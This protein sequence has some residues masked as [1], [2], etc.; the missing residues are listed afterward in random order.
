[1][2]LTY[3]ISLLGSCTFIN[4]SSKFCYLVSHAIMYLEQHIR[5][6]AEAALSSMY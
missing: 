1:M 3:R 4:S 5:R 2:D 6:E